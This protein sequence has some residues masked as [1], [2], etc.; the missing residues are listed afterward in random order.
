MFCFHFSIYFDDYGC[1]FLNKPVRILLQQEFDISKTHI[2]QDKVYF[3]FEPPPPHTLAPAPSHPPAPAPSHPPAPASPSSS[4]SSVAV[5]LS[6][7]TTVTAL[8]D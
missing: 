8:T 3:L 5:Y 7:E 6:R 4:S 1:D 2:K